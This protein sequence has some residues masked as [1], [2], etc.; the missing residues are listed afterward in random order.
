MNSFIIDQKNNPNALSIIKNACAFIRNLPKDKRWE[1][2]VKPYR[3]N[4]SAAQNRYLWGVVY[5][6]IEENDG[7]VFLNDNTMPI[8]QSARIKPSEFIHEYFK[9][10]FLEVGRGGK[11]VITR[12]TAKLNT[13][14]F[15]EYVEKIMQFAS[16]RMGIYIPTP[17]EKGLADYEKW[18]SGR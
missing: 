2:I 9:Q 18:W 12:S 4:R 11:K 10:E 17:A 13:E 3:L 14:E 16:T 7:G 5:A 1:V 8:I 15:A 6:T